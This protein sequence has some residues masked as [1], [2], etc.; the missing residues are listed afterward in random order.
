MA[1]EVIKGQATVLFNS[2]KSSLSFFIGPGRR[3]SLQ[4]LGSADGIE[5]P[6]VSL[7]RLRRPT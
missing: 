4:S 2:Q 6:I 5:T 1:F 3:A 7:R